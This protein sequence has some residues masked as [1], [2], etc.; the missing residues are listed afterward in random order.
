M[1]ERNYVMRKI[2]Q[3]KKVF[4]VSCLLWT[5]Y[6]CAGCTKSDEVTVYEPDTA[7]V[8]VAETAAEDSKNEDRGHETDENSQST[9]EGS[10]DEGIAQDT[11]NACPEEAV[12]YVQVCGAVHRPG[13]YELHTG[14]RV[15]QA[16]ELAGGMTDA[17]NGQAINQACEVSDGQ[18]I[19]VY[20]NEEWHEIC[21]GN[22]SKIP[23]AMMTADGQ[24]E[25][26]S[27]DGKID[28]NLAD[29]ETLTD[30][31]GIGKTLA[32]R[33]IEYRDSKGKFQSI[34]EIKNVSGI[35]DSLFEKIKDH[36]KV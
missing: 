9:T 23:D 7:G 5:A 25:V 14:D 10:K 34:E 13:V 18:M 28:I 2:Y 31:S 6:L 8:L 30:L 35:G 3:W 17:A 11:E 21:E 1:T 12:I 26:P 33:I 4:F 32:G 36:I 15:F 20:S 24:Q 19:Y 22:I 16:I 27:Q 29:A